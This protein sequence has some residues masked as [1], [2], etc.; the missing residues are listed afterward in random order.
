LTP[1]EHHSAIQ[2]VLNP[3]HCPLI[4]PTLPKLPYDDV[5]GDDVMGDNVKNIA[6]VKED[7]IRYCPLILS[8]DA[9]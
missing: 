1:G 6:E 2:P 4:Q 8:F 5:M 3:P 7:G 9:Q